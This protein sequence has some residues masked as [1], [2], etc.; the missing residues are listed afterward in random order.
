MTAEGY[1]VLGQAGRP[2]K[3]PS[4][5]LEID[6][7][8]ELRVDGRRVGRLALATVPQGQPLTET[9][10][11]YYRGPGQPLTG[12]ASTDVG[13]LQGYLESSNV[14]LSTQMS[15]M[16]SAQRA[17][18]ANTRVVTTVDEISQETIN[19]KR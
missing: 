8:G 1:P 16:L 17:Y 11:G 6:K 12:R 4:G 18:Q 19:L 10:N 14:D 2:L 15:S 7:S 9:G 5:T 3:V 13:V